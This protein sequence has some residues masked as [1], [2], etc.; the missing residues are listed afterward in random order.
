LDVAMLFTRA[1]NRF[2]FGMELLST[3]VLRDINRILSG[4]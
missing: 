4:L 2:R 3:F 1:Y